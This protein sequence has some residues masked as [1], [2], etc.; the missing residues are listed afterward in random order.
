MTEPVR[1]DR[2]EDGP[3]PETQPG[4]G[5]NRRGLLR[6]VLL[7]GGAVAAA[8]VGGVATR[9]YDDAHS[10]SSAPASSAP[11]SA[12]PPSTGRAPGGGTLAGQTITEDFFGLTTDGKLIDGLFPV[13]SDGVDTAPVIAAAQAF[14][15]ALTDDQKK[16]TQYTARS[17]EWRMW[18]NL[19]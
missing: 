4:R 18:S 17:T 7:A 3:P 5:M 6:G 1:T 2:A 16:K 15:S 11:S 8:G 19:E 10:S 9:L 12:T 13:R 14:L